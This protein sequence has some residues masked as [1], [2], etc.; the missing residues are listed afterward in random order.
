MIRLVRSE[1]RKVMTTR[2]WWGLLIGVVATSI[3][4][5]A[6]AASL[7]GMSSNGTRMPGVND[8]AVVRQT[9]TAGLSFGYLIALALG[10]ITMSG[11]YRHQTITA[12]V[13]ASP[14]RHRIVLAKLGALTVFGVGYGLAAVLTGLAVGIPI[15]L[16]RGGSARLLSDDVPRALV[17]AVLAV[18]LWAILGLGVGT[19]I[20]NQIVALLVAIGVAWLAEPLLTVALN[21]LHAGS[22][23]RFMP[24]A[25][26]SALVTP[27]TSAGGITQSFLPWWG[28]AL[29]LLGYAAIS[30][31]LGA[32]ITLRRD[33]S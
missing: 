11:E 6:L 24:T 14:R 4:G 1:V 22:V 8:P 20:R 17:L 15:I 27:N 10:I 7:A 13:L 29:V 21:L 28:G 5:S 19:L 9:Y 2:L 12:T 31:A 18:V 32:A 3:L 16:G 23:A 30:G 33:I 25:A 26:T